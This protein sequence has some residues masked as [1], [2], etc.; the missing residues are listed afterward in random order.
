MTGVTAL[1]ALR[2]PNFALFWSAQ[3][4]SGFGDKITVFALAFVTWE[5]TRS[6]VST[7]LAVVIST[8]PYAVFGFF[9]GAI[10][11]AL[12]RRR[13]MVACDIIRVACIG[14]IPVLLSAGTP[15]IVVYALVFVAALS[16]A[17]FYPAR[18]AIVPDIVPAN[19][20][21]AG[22]SMIY[23]SD[24]TVEIVGALVAGFL[25]AAL[26]ESAFYVDALT[27][28]L[29]AGLLAKIAMTE[30]PPRRLSWSGLLADAGDGV[31]TLWTHTTLR[32]NTIFS[33][34][35]QLSLPLVNGLSPVLIFREYGLGP[36]Q[37]G[38]SEA[39]IALGAVLSSLFYPSVLAGARK[40][41]AIVVGFASFGLV[42][43]AFGAS[44]AFP[45]ALALFV[46]VG[47]TN[48]VFF[49]SNMTLIQ[50]VT[51]PPL[52]GRVFGARLALLNLTWLP[53]I[54]VLA[55][56]AESF[57]VQFLFAAAGAFTILVALVGSFFRSV[58]DAG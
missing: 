17:V 36:E 51:P 34:L 16:S 6:A 50:E 8:V 19:G 41:R 58:R 9:G 21:G 1:A 15:L 42:L 35:A 28:A 13:T 40:G 43:F 26:H 20:L 32:A 52:R 47:A 54:L 29:S 39:A 49:V 48:V 22:N 33:L 31:R 45:V 24:R 55:G 56:A 5:L 37:F 4:V 11:D 18:L 3:V 7:V 23:A 46:L 44:P 27:F 12:G 53:V 38:A 57:S 2:S 10:A 25:V 14:A 30:A